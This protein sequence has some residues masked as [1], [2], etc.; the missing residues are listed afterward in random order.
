MK[1]NLPE[2]FPHLEKDWDI[3]KNDKILS[4]YGKHSKYRAWWKCHQCHH[5]WRSA[6]RNRADKGAKCPSCVK[7][8]PYLESL[9]YKFPE[10]D[11]MIHSH[12][13]IYS[14]SNNKI[15]GI[16]LHCRSHHKIWWEC[17]NGHEFQRTIT[18]QT[19][20]SKYKCPICK[21]EKTKTIKKDIIVDG[22][23][24][25]NQILH[26]LEPEQYIELM[27]YQNFKCWLSGLPFGYDEK[28]KKFIDTRIRVIEKEDDGDIIGHKFIKPHHDSNNKIAP[29]IDHCH[30]KGFIRAILNGTV[31]SWEDSWIDIT[32]PKDLGEIDIEDIIPH[33]RAYSIKRNWDSNLSAKENYDN[34][35]GF[36]IN[37]QRLEQYY[38]ESPAEKLFGKINFKK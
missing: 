17:T 22:Y 35:L 34:F 32:Y 9:A 36:K 23:N 10:L 25:T 30:D 5:T 15:S 28:R 31:N 6:I 29:H 24:I 3:E 21:I 18:S 11:N 37:P 7:K 16:D 19:H 13:N 4:D 2:K 14:W 8:P 26:G 1:I 12:R 20:Y 33:Y 27:K 38:I